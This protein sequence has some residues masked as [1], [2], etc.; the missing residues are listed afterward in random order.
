MKWFLLL[1]LNIAFTLLAYVLAPI[2]PAFAT[3][4]G[5]LPTWLTWFDTPD[6]RLDGDVGFRTEHAPFKGEQVGWRRYINRV[7]WLIRNPAYGFDVAIAVDVSED[8]NLQVSGTRSMGGNLDEDGWFFATAPGA[9]QLYVTHH[10]TDTH[11]TK[12]NLGWKIWMRPG[13]CSFVFS[14]L[15]IWKKY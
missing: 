2:L 7:V 5:V 14:P 4:Y 11:T 1:P 8:V 10:W 6:N 15:G 3:E 9:W 13:K 12:I